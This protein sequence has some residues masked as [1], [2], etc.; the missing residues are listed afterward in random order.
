MVEPSSG[1]AGSHAGR[2]AGRP[3]ALPS[4][5]TSHPTTP[6]AAGRSRRFLGGGA[7][8]TSCPDLAEAIPMPPVPKPPAEAEKE[9]VASA[10][11]AMTNAEKCGFLAAIYG[12]YAS[13]AAH[14]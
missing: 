13:K 7:L 9:L 3:A 2:Q 1:V 4:I 11:R 8:D 5:A 6:A 10:K 14:T 12:R